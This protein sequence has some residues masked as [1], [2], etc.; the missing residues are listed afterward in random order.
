MRLRAAALLCAAA[1]VGLV[2]TQAR[3]GGLIGALG[4]LRPPPPPESADTE[5]GREC[6]DRRDNDN[7]GAVDCQDD[8]CEG[9]PAC[10]LA[11]AA[12]GTG[13]AIQDLGNQLADRLRPGGGGDG[14]GDCV[15]DPQGLL[16]LDARAET[17][18]CGIA[19]R[20]L[21]G[22]GR[23]CGIDA[24][25]ELDAIASRPEVVMVLVAAQQS[26]DTS[27]V[28]PGTNMTAIC[29]CACAAEPP[30]RSR[31]GPPI[32]PGQG[33]YDMTG[34][35]AGTA[36][37]CLYTPQHCCQA[38]CEAHGGAWIDGSSQTCGSDPDCD[39]DTDSTICG[40]DALCDGVA[41][42]DGTSPV[43]S[44]GTLGSS[45]PWG[46]RMCT[47]GSEPACAD[48]TVM[49]PRPSALPDTSCFP[50]GSGFTEERC[51]ADPAGAGIGDPS[52]WDGAAFT[53]ANC[54]P[55]TAGG[56]GGGARA[57][58]GGGCD[59]TALDTACQ[60][61]S[62]DTPSDEDW[63]RL[64][65]DTLCVNPCV[66][67]LIP[68][69]GNPLMTLMMGRDEASGIA[70]LEPMCAPPPPGATGGGDGICDVGG[71][72]RECQARDPAEICPGYTPS[73]VCGTECAQESIDCRDSDVLDEERV[74][75][76][77][78]EAM[79]AEPDGVPTGAP[80][81]GACSLRAAA[82]LCNEAE[83]ELLDLMEEQDE[84]GWEPSRGEER[85]TGDER[86]EMCAVSPATVGSGL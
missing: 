86:S 48:G 79:C 78:L 19:L 71:L 5:T 22:A 82:Q 73:C 21:R 37:H 81:D 50:P 41:C 27:R 85:L 15:E 67:A 53:F 1:A 31:G 77:F 49:P 72:I 17:A 69:A 16:Q 33:C 36:H 55:R 59:L 4:R 38:G 23:D 24:R 20:L 84:A 44:D 52:C 42:A 46:G 40:C 43:C 45:L 26:I 64:D 32:T 18:I 58:G 83:L 75:V 68:C 3:N 66:Q 63:E 6:I 29:P 56:R 76:L 2:P 34:S 35:I 11:A 61:G 25:L 80:G 70:A 10:R 9:F 12:G 51:C 54:C 65:L 60:P 7:D 74:N 13:G 39:D 8:D 14:A 62:A 28:A 30:Q 57:P 47:D